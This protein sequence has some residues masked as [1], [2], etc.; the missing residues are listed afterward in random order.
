LAKVTEFITETSDGLSST[1]MCFVA[2][3]LV[4][5]DQGL[6]PIE[7]IQAGDGVLS[8]DSQTGQQTYKPVVQIVIKR[9]SGTGAG[10]VRFP[11]KLK[12]IRYIHR[13]A[14]AALAS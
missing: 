13:S 3:T 14:I 2:G 6:R 11:L 5:T 4:H 1:S 7:T 12:S 9:G 10:Q 8:R